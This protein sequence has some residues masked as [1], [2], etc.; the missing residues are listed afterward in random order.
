MRAH[1]EAAPRSVVLVGAES[2]GKSSLAARLTG[3]PTETANLRGTTVAVERYAGRDRVV[4]DTPGLTLAADSDAVQRAL[5]TLA[6]DADTDAASDTDA[7]DDTDAANDAGAVVVAVVRATSLDADLALVAPLV[8]GRV[9]ALAITHRDR[10]PQTAAAARATLARL[11]AELGVPVVLLDARRVDHVDRAALADALA[12]PAPF[13]AAPR[14]TPTGWEARQRRGPL[15]HPTLLALAALALLLAPATA[16]VWLANALAGALDPLVHAALDPL[17]H[18][19][20][21]LPAPLSTVLAGGYGIVAMLPFL[22]VWALPTVLAFALLVAALK[23]SGL[24]ELICAG[25]HPLV[26]PLG[27]HGRDLAPFVMGYGCNVPAIVKTRACSACTRGQ[28][29]GAIAFGSA[30]S[31]QL[32]ATGA[33]FAAAGQ[34]WLTAP[35]VLFLLATTVLYTAATRRGPTPRVLDPGARRVF[36]CR[37]SRDALWREA[38][39]GI[40]QF[41]GRALPIFVAICLLASLLDAAG[42]LT[43][44]AAMLAPAMRVFGLPGDAALGVVLASVRKDGLLIFGQDRLSA[45]LTPLQLLTAVY[46]AGVLLPCLVT[47]LTIARELG[48]R[49]ALRLLARQAAFAALFTLLLAWG[50]RGL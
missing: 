22:L 45:A 29:V 42:A 33:V 40:R 24:L 13:A 6:G 48:A 28:A 14:W 4:L 47:A 10:A 9:G 11:R 20:A 18:V 3:A 31:Y 1:A 19:L 37:P 15:E 25:L 32:G 21:G 30:C 46:L 44:L 2:A 26:R 38:A 36:V 49:H 35:F 8:A 16:A 12:A 7:D 23:T 27:L 41:A 34:A 5:R 50:G 43:A 17:L 39:A